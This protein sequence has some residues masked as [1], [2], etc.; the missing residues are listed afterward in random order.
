[1]ELKYLMEKLHKNIKLAETKK[2][3][4]KSTFFAERKGNEPYYI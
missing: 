4:M 3:L 2:T 1:M